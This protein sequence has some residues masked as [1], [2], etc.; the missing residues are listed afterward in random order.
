[1]ATA[2][3]EEQLGALLARAVQQFNTQ[4]GGGR[5]A[6]STTT[7]AGLD[8]HARRILRA[9]AG[10]GLDSTTLAPLLN[11]PLLAAELDQAVMA[12]QAYREGRVRGLVS[13][14]LCWTITPSC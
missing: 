2:G 8:A 12:A 7:A 3:P 1:M 6:V 9:A 13:N 14:S 4:R 5:K 11:G 10:H